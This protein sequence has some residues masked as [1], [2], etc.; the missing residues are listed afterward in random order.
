MKSARVAV[1]FTGG[2]I[3]MT[4]TG[5]DGTAIPTLTGDEIC[6]AVPELD[7]FNLELHDVGQLPG[8]HMSPEICIELAARVQQVIRDG[9]DGVVITHGTDTIEETAFLLD[10][11]HVSAHPVALVGAMRTQDELSWDG[12]VNL[13]SGCLVAASAAGR[14]HGVMVVMNNVI[15]AAS[16]VVKTYT[17]SLDTFVSPDVGAL[18]FIDRNEVT[19]YRQPVHRQTLP[20]TQRLGRVEIIYA[21]ASSDGSLVDAAVRQGFNGLVVA[22]MGRGNVTPAMAEALLYALKSG[23]HVVVCSRCWAGRVAP[24]YGYAGGGATLLEAG[25]IF[26]PWYNPLKARI[27]LSLVLGAHLDMAA[28]RAFFGGGGPAKPEH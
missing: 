17:E 19:F 5:P 20:P 22:A 12:P 23:V 18:G 21:S 27:A 28:M 11:L 13:F 26:A 2:T 25:A 9:C 7:E 1:L 16:E 24:V 4:H 8:P 15:H 10:M 3:S 14:N 6:S